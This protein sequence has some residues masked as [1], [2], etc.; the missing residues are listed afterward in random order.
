[1]LNKSLKARI[2]AAL[3]VLED[4]QVWYGRRDTCEVRYEFHIG[5]NAA[6]ISFIFRD[7]QSIIASLYD[8]DGLY[9]IKDVSDEDVGEVAADLEAR[10]TENAI[11]QSHAYAN[12]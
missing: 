6:E 8:N 5:E 9:E 2:D 12:R 10:A 1:M 7:G 4:Y 3:L 11:A